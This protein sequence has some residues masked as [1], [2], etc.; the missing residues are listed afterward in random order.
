MPRLRRLLAPCLLLTAMLAT[1]IAPTASAQEYRTVTGNT[2][3]VRTAPTGKVVGVVHKGQRV[4]TTSTVK[5]GFRKL[6]DGRW[7]SNR[8]L[9]LATGDQTG[10]WITCPAITLD[11]VN[12]P[13]GRI[14]GSMRNVVTVN[15]IG[16]SSAHVGLWTRTAGRK[17]AFT[18]T[19]NETGRVGSGGIVPDAQRRQGTDATPAGIYSM[20][21]GFSN[22]AAPATKLSWRV[23]G[24]TDYWVQDNGSSLYNTYATS[25]R[26][27]RTSEAEHL[28]DYPTQYRY[29]IVINFNA[30]KTRNKG[31]GIFLHVNGKGATAGC[32]SVSQQMMLKVAETIAPGTLINI[33]K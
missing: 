17:C 14:S 31:A 9:T 5:S 8:Y 30:A 25:A 20:T 24:P 10:S 16:G 21:T 32:V 7:I 15:G 23:T 29:A 22:G 28:R 4:A 2:V 27:F 18:R 33:V 1:L 3:N 13:A 11:G 6:A 12:F 19:L 26:G